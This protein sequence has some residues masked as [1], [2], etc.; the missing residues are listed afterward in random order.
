MVYPRRFFSLVISV[1]IF[2]GLAGSAYADY[3]FTF[4]DPVSPTAMDILKIHT[5]TSTIL[6]VMLSIIFA[7]VGYILY[8]HRKSRGFQ[9]DLNLHKTA[10][11]RWTWLIIPVLVLGVDLT[12]AGKAEQV[13]KTL[14]LVP[15]NEDMMDI[16][17]TGHQWWW[18]Y[19]YPDYGIKIESRYTPQ[20]QAGAL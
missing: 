14:W 11:A 6:V 17:V 2:F 1:V 20:E 9:P 4:P 10:F 13:L 8:F 3:Q 12:I 15:Q 5:L 7:V 16:K 18:E 19:E